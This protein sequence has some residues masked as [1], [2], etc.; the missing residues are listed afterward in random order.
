MAVGLA[1]GCAV[2]LVVGLDVGSGVDGAKVGI[3]DGE[4]VGGAEVGA[5]VGEADGPWL[6]AEKLGDVVGA[7]LQPAQL[8]RHT[9][10][11]TAK[12]QQSVHMA[13]VATKLQY[14][15][16]SMF[17]NVGSSSAYLSSQEVGAWLGA[18]VGFDVGDVVRSEVV[19]LAV[20][21]EVV[22]LAVGSEVVGSAVL[23]VVFASVESA[24]RH[25][26]RIVAEP[27]LSM[28]L[29]ARHTGWGTHWV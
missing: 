5:V 20:G 23:V 19:G 14:S 12:S 15:V 4:A 2:G 1:V 26:R 22:G 25:V 3:H 28:T 17:T 16:D 11:S 7:M 8:T 21:S 27:G 24:P 18:L 29:G 10:L 9:F 13:F 6:G